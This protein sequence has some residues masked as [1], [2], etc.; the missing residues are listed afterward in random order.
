[1]RTELVVG[2]SFLKARETAGLTQTQAADI[3][4]VDRSYISDVEHGKKT[5]TITW[6]LCY[7]AALRTTVSELLQGIE[8][9]RADA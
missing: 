9:R 1:M 4:G 8:A 5:P 3:A 6:A 2:R 7:A